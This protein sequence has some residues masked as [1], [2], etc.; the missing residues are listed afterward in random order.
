MLSFNSSLKDTK[1]ALVRG[2]SVQS[3]FQFLIK[4]YKPT[5]AMRVDKRIFQFLIKGYYF[6]CFFIA[7]S[8]YA[9]NS[10]L[11]DTQSLLDTGLVLVLFQFLIKG[12]VFFGSSFMWKFFTNFQF[13]IKGYKKKK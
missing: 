13:L 4:G 10:S 1:A 11:K 6:L 3:I 2:V 9:F 12:Y 7:L 8:L 5:S